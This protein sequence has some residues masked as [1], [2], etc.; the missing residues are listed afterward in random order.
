[1]TDQLVDTCMGRF[2]WSES[3]VASAGHAIQ[4]AAEYLHVQS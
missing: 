4:P 2:H 3:I 1:M